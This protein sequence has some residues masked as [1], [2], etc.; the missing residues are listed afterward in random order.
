MTDRF[1]YELPTLPISGNGRLPSRTRTQPVFDWF[2]DDP[3]DMPNPGHRYDQ[4]PPKTELYDSNRSPE[5]DLMD[6]VENCNWN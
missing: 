1:A 3:P 6:T 4:L 5:A 2:M